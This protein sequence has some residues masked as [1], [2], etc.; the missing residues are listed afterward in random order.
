MRKRIISISVGLILFH[1]L[2]LGIY[3]FVTKGL[4]YYDRAI[5]EKFDLLFK[6]NSAQDIV[7][8]GS[9]RTYYGVN[10]LLLEQLSGKTVVNMGLEGAKLNEMELALKAYLF[11]HPKPQK[12]F[13]MLDP[14]SFDYKESSIYNKIY[15]A[16]YFDNDS[17]YFNFKKISGKKAIVWKWLPY[18]LV[19]EFDDYTRLKAVKGLFTKKKPDVNVFNY[20]GFCLLKRQFVPTELDFDVSKIDL[21]TGE[22]Q[23]CRILDLCTSNSIEV[24]IIQGPFL[25]TYYDRNKI[26]EFYRKID[27]SISEKFK[28]VEMQDFSLNYESIEY[29]K[30]ETHL[31]D[32]GSTRYTK[33]LFTTFIKK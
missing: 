17:L 9:S 24:S 4:V 28:A 25:A 16:H 6:D 33:D 14:H 3:Y 5:Y 21:K 23:L 26:D 22:I 13:L 12:L 1:C 20:K 2:M 8:L 30:D 27:N 29:F 7:I 10:P 32:L 15:M 18:S 11:V 19:S 31:N